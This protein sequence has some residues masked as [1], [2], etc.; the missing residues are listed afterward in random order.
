MFVN[1]I[2]AIRIYVFLS[3]KIS[4]NQPKQSKKKDMKLPIKLFMSQFIFRYIRQKT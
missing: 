3:K 1:D 2:G 4:Y